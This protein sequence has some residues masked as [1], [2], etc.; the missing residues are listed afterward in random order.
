MNDIMTIPPQSLAALV[1]RASRMD[2][3]VRLDGSEIY[4]FAMGNIVATVIGPLNVASGYQSRNQHRAAEIKE[5]LKANGV[6]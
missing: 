3:C 2:G 1:D 5:K 6:P 4:E